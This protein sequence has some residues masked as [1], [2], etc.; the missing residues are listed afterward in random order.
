MTAKRTSLG[1]SHL[2]NS[3]LFAVLMQ[4]LPAAAAENS[5]QFAGISLRGFGSLGLARSS[6]DQAEIVRDLSQPRGITNE[7]SGRSDS[8][9]GLQGNYQATDQLE[10]VAQVVTRY[11]DGGNYKPELTWAFLKYEPNAY[12]SLRAGRF[13]TEF[14]MRADS[15][16]IGYSY[17]AVRPAPDFFATLPFSYIDGIDVQLTTPLGDGLLRS[18][19]YRGLAREK[20][21]ISVEHLDINAGPMTGG[22]LDYQQGAWQWRGGYSQIRFSHDMPPPIDQ[23]RASLSAASVSTGIATAQAA[24]DALALNGH[25]GH[26][27]SLGAAYDDGPLQ[28]NAMLSR[29]RHTSVAFENSRS[30]MFII[31]YRVGEVTPFAGFSWTRSEAKQLATGLP[32]ATAGLTTLNASVAAVL[33]D[34]HSDQNTSTLGL[35]WDFRRNMALKVQADVV[36]GT[37]Q[38]IFPYR[39]ETPLWNGRTNVLSVSLDFVF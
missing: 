12:L 14:F 37:R 27:Y 25:V 32:N 5:T 34:S 17:L 29:I 30:G 24:S 16:L 6:S 23:L 36:R 1:L 13:G 18:R 21:P 22:Y 11:H 28:A 26:Y 39:R 33:A 3:F 20:I 38:S 9:L 4:I 7:W 19:L 10:A 8:L 35:R 15:R 2:A 31:G